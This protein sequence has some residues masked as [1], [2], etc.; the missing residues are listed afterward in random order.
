MSKDV[1]QELKI[2]LAKAKAEV[3]AL[4][5]ALEAL[6]GHKGSKTSGWTPAKRAAKAKAMKRYWAKVKKGPKAPKARKAKGKPAAAEFAG[7]AAVA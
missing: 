4:S 3:S 6:T 2:Q 1:K 7:V 5:K